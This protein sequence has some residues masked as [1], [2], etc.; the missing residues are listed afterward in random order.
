MFVDETKIKVKAGD[1][2]NGC[3]SFRREKYILSDLGG[4]PRKHSPVGLASS[5]L[6]YCIL[7]KTQVDVRRPAVS[8]ETTGFRYVRHH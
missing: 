5:A 8:L 1:G 4:A 2:G 6:K 7:K 3:V